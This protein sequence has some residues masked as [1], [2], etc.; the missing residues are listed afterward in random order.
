MIKFTVTRTKGGVGKTTLTAT[1]TTLWNLLGLLGE[2]RAST[3]SL[4][5]FDR[6][7]APAGGA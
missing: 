7:I 6:P 1:S 3:L 4:R 5:G 2:S